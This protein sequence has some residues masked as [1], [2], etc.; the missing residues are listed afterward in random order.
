MMLTRG[1]L[2]FLAGLGGGDL[3]L[4]DAEFRPQP[5]HGAVGRLPLVLV[6]G[7]GQEALDAGAL[8]GDAAA[9][10]LGDRARDDDAGHRGIE[11]LV[12]AAHGAF[13]AVLAEF[14]FREAGDDDGQFMRRQ[15]IG[16]VQH[17]G[18]GQV[19]AAHRAVDDHLQA[20]DG[21][22]DVDGAPVAA[23]AVMI[24]D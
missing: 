18:D 4:L 15:R 16:V 9:D 19:L 12:G 14:F 22:E 20:L 5:V 8:R 11:S 2:A 24:E 23:G 17:G 1:L 13:G 21:G 10:H 3:L 7:A 6:D